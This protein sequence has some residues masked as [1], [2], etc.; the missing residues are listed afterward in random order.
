M[1]RNLYKFIAAGAL[2]LST[3]GAQ[4][5]V[6][7]FENALPTPTGPNFF[8]ADY[9][10]FKFGTNDLATTAWFYTDQITP[11][12]TPQSP[13]HYIAT[14]FQLYTGGAFEA[15]QS[16]TSA[17]DFVFD[18]AWFS[19][20]GQIRYQLY[21]NGALVHTSGNSVA[22]NDTQ[23]IFFASGYSG[24]VDELVVLG[25]QGFYAMDDFTYNT[26]QNVVP[27]PTSL[28]LVLLAGAVGVG[29]TRRRSVAVSAA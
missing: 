13:S 11:F 28:A 4:A 27:E 17:V 22:L 18:G 2:A 8:L 26:R 3:V 6:L 10:G 20:E 14:D 1:T 12:Y 16:I 21:N 23:P 19:G 29:V 25:K 15:A 9:F 24:L 7:T 5:A